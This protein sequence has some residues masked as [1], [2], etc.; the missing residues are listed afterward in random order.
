[1]RDN[2]IWIDRV[3]VFA[4]ISVVVSHLIG[5]LA[6][7]DIIKN[8][9]WV[10]WIEFYLYLFHVPLFF[11]CSGYLY[12]KYTSITNIFELKQNI[13]KKFINLSIP[14]F[15]FTLITILLK[16]IFSNIV[17]NVET[18]VL[19]ILFIT[20]TAP[21][22]YLYILFFF[23]VVT[24]TMSTLK[25]EYTI[26]TIAL[27]M[28][29][30]ISILFDL[31]GQYLRIDLIEKFMFFY[32]WFVLGMIIANNKIIEKIL[33]KINLY[34]GLVLIA[35]ITFSSI[36]LFD[37]IYKSE[38]VKFL[39]AVILCLLICSILMKSSIR[40]NEKLIKYTMPIFLMHTIFAAGI[41]SFLLYLNVYNVI[42]HII[43]GLIVSLVLPIIVA[44]ILD[45]TMYLNILLYPL[46]T[47]KNIKKVE[48][49]RNYEYRKNNS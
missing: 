47:I 1:M 24:F 31:G 13:I 6:E 23:Y 26:F 29:I 48:R 10:N 27:V 28:K 22:W 17:N 43:T 38:I 32:I 7:S 3:K 15:T 42:I 4:C 12:Q 19:K 21:Y 16:V 25:Q 8:I 5:G 46:K 2:I 37:S 9:F 18:D 30:T 39:L 36:V 20:P 40:N 33:S 45:K 49:R 35:A 41:R 11:I 44:N 14:Y 34:I